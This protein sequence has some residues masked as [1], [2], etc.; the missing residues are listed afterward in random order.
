MRVWEGDEAG[1]EGGI[2]INKPNVNIF[3]IPCIN[4]QLSLYAYKYT[5]HTPRYTGSRVDLG[6]GPLDR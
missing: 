2:Y 3:I 1:R 6:L 5:I 4:N